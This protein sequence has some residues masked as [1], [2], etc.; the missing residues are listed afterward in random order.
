M[1]RRSRIPSQPRL[2]R[3]TRSRETSKRPGKN[4]GSASSRRLSLE[5]VGGDQKAIAVRQI[6]ER[7]AERAEDDRILIHHL[8][9]DDVARISQLVAPGVGHIALGIESKRRRRAVCR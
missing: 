8:H 6:R 2:R 4:R 9:Y 7:E 1:A 3:W 5:D